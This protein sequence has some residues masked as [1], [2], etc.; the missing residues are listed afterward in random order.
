[1]P[2]GETL[3]CKDHMDGPIFIFPLIIFNY[4][5]TD[6]ITLSSVGCETAKGKFDSTVKKSVGRW[7]NS[8]YELVIRGTYNTQKDF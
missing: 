5:S 8:E 2:E 7:S 1:M 6:V 4:I 3:T